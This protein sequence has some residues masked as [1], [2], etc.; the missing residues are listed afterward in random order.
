M[1]QQGLLADKKRKGRC[2]GDYFFFFVC[3]VHFSCLIEALDLKRICTLK[4]VLRKPHNALT[5]QLSLSLR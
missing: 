2:S 3:E 4:K 1:N 5:F